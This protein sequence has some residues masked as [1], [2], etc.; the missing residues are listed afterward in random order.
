MYE[1]SIS[2]PCTSTLHKIYTFTL[3][4]IIFTPTSQK[5]LVLTQ[6]NYAERSRE[7][8][9]NK[10][11]N[12]KAVMLLHGTFSSTL[13]AEQKRR[14]KFQKLVLNNKKCVNIHPRRCV[15]SP[16]R[17][18][19]WGTAGSN[20]CRDGA[21]GTG[22]RQEPGGQGRKSWMFGWFQ[23]CTAPLVGYF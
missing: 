10:K 12:H 15:L 11:K 18:W 3:H 8:Q 17:A 6:K 14:V 1:N 2:K 4:K 16:C 9:G 5:L 23:A 22:C 20:A 13:R 21:A 7:I 19:G